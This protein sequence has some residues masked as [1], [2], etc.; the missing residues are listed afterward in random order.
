VDL[1]DRVGREA[2]LK[3]HAR[4]KPF[5]LTVD[6]AAVAAR[7]TGFS[8]ASLANLLNEAAIVAA[9]RNRSDISINEVNIQAKCASRKHTL[10]TA[11]R[12]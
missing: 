9:R 5:D 12:F 3:V 7:T 10:P 2:I 4:S 8:G 1:P 6:L 11:S